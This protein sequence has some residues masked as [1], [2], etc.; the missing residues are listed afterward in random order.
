MFVQE[1]YLENVDA[2]FQQLVGQ[3]VDAQEA[4]NRYSDLRGQKNIKGL[5]IVDKTVLVGA[6]LY[7]FDQEICEVMVTLTWPGYDRNIIMQALIDYLSKAR[8]K[9]L[10]LYSNFTTDESWLKSCGFK[11][12]DKGIYWRDFTYPIAFVFG[13][14]GAHGAFL[15]GAYE[16]LAA[17]HVVP[18]M[19]YGVSVGAI[20]GMSLMHLDT[21]IANATWAELTT[22][23]VY[24]VDH[25]SL[26][27][28]Q[29]TR[30]LARNFIT[31]RYYNKASLRQV[32]QPAVE[33]ELASPPL[34]D[35]TLVATEFPSL[36][37]AVYRVTKETTVTELTDWILAS[38]A[39]YP[40]V[41]P[42]KIGEK[43]YIDGGYSNN[44]P[45]N[46]AA[47]DGAKEIYAFSIMDNSIANLN[48]P[49]DVN[50][51]YIRTPWELGPLLDFIPEMS[52][53]HRRLGFLRTKQVLGEYA[54]YYYAFTEPVN[55]TWLGGPQLIRW[56]A[57]DP[58]TAPLAELLNEAPVWLVW[59]QW[60]ERKAENKFD[61]DAKA[62]GLATIER[63]A[64]LLAVD[65]LKTYTLQGFIDEIIKQ[66]TFRTNL[67]SAKGKISRPYLLANIALVLTGLLYLLSKSAKQGRI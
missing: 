33:K 49:D 7:T 6:V 8:V 63:L 44:I 51:H 59:T 57:T 58:I 39:F 26:N 5:V 22:Q 19:L 20:T 60:L 31:H 1:G 55:F 42:V 38:S 29:F 66:G 64:E 28:R 18:T 45:A 9:Q 13:G 52:Q 2:V 3:F 24:E 37:E 65:P 25:V 15:T 61:G 16:A 23:M 14:G 48:V 67:P 53:R 50:L 35:F 12:V 10:R 54:G 47:T 62:M 43:R 11:H 36:K 4:R 17:A 41:A 27:R 32:I 21:T 56:L 30:N 40:L 46:L 34:A